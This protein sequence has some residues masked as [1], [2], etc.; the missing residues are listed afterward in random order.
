M[1]GKRLSLRED[2]WNNIEIKEEDINF[3]YNYLFEKERPISIDDLTLALV[4]EWVQKIRTG[5]EKRQQQEGKIF[6]PKDQYTIGDWVLFPSYNWTKG[7]VVGIRAGVNP[8]V[9]EFN[10]IDVVFTDGSQKSFASNLT[11]HVLNEPIQFETDNPLLNVNS[12]MASS[13]KLIATKLIEILSKNEDL[14]SIAAKWFPKALLVDVNIGYLNLAEALLDMAGGG[15]LTTEDILKQIDLPTDVN[16]ELTTFSLDYAMK[17]DARFDEVGASGI[18]VWYLKRLEPEWVQTPPE[19][20]QYH[21]VSYEENGIDDLKNMLSAQIIDELED[22]LDLDIFHDEITVGLMYPHW[23]SGA[24]PLGNALV[25][26]FPTAVESPRVRFTFVDGNNGK[27][28]SGWVV[29]PSR[30]IGGLSEWYEEQGVIPGSLIRLRKGEN[31]GEVIIH[32]SRR[33]STRDWIRTALV[34]SDGGIVFAMLKQLV[35]TETDE[36]MAIFIPDVTLLDALWAK[37]KY[38]RYEL[39]K[40]IVH[41]MKEL[42][43]LNPQGHVHF[44]ELYATVNLRY[45][46]PPGPILQILTE[47]PWASHLGDL[48][49]NLNRE[50]LDD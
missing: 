16:P 1:H 29:R 47:Q 4:E 42:I 12:V 32:C 49:F 46:C 44:E 25:H 35:L 39:T 23:R 17:K 30:Y 27:R 20:L 38:G 15:P 48:Y 13:G 14:V 2:Y 9:K 50:F 10:V 3:L 31:P 43:K 19:Y 40:I 8:E 24:L 7:E 5:F 22:R 6:A 26:L 18:V 28:F 45:R 41:M 34:G 33:R 36:R 37:A 11:E 21:A